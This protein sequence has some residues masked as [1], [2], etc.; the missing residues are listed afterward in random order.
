MTNFEWF[1]LIVVVIAV[2]L[3]VAVAVTLWT[4][5][6]A[7]MRKRHNRDDGA[8]AEPVKRRAT[9][10]DSLTPVVAAPALVGMQAASTTGSPET[11]I[12]T[13]DR[14]AGG[15]GAQVASPS[16]TDAGSSAG[17]ADGGS[18]SSG[19]DGGGSTS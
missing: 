16:S 12:D 11:A 8:P 4:L 14:D 17:N 7:R 18:S 2:P 9:R 15:D 1:L 3:V 19:S 5:E 10:D 6:Q 13:G